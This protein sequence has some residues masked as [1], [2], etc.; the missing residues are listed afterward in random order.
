MEDYLNPCSINFR[1]VNI[2][3]A[4]GRAF[5]SRRSLSP[6]IRKSAPDSRQH[7]S[8]ILSDGSL[9]TE[10][11]FRGWTTIV[12]VTKVAKPEINAFS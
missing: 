9:Q 11:F 6:V 2:V 1:G 4:N 3:R 5:K 7:S 10:I 12:F 8:S